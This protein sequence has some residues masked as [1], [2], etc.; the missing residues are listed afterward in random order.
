MRA[1]LLV[2]LAAL[3][4]SCTR[5]PPLLEQILELGELRVITTE[6]PATFYYGSDAPRGI[7][8]ELAQG[9]AARLGVDLS[10]IVSDKPGSLLPEVARR[11]AHLAAGSLARASHEDVVTF[12]PAYQ[13]VQQQVIYRAG[14]K[15]PKELADL[16][17]ARIDVPAG[18][19]QAALLDEAL[20]E[21]PRL[22]WREDPRASYE[23]LVRRVQEGL[24]DYTIV[25]SH[26]FSLLRHSYPETRVAFGIGD[27]FRI[28]W[29]LPKGA[30]ALREQVAAYFA[31]IEATGELERILERYYFAARNFDYV[32]SR[33]FLRHIETRLPRYIEHFREAERVSG[34]DWRLLAAIGYQ[35]SHWNPQ[36]VSPT[37][38]RGLMMLTQEAASAVDVAD[39]V[40]PRESVFG[41]ALYFRTVLEKLPE[42]IPEPD[43]TW[44]AVA[45]Y[46]IGFGHLEDARIITEIQGGNP[47]RWDH[48]RARLPLLADEAWHSRVK[49][50][51]ARGHVAVT[52]TDNVRRYYELLTW[53]AD[54]EFVSEYRA[55]APRPT[56]S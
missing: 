16:V 5:P 52:Y 48:V 31:E 4:G 20:A 45:A 50:G 2:T 30:D 3:L 6:G 46:N 7:E 9:F 12:G 8:F 54:R 38:V 33:A 35:E 27:E 19:A 24:I 55:P 32:G 14:T 23:E 56:K 43:R 53:I 40:D 42:R 10:L 37:G 41:G 29:A 26:K 44:L 34:I 22:L 51:F 47:D 28:A 15:R 49:R 21:H 18:S 25:P 1:L 39:R 11:G 17:G 36:A 13:R